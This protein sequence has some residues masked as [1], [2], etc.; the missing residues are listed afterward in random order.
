MFYAAPRTLDGVIWDRKPNKY[1]VERP[2]EKPWPHVIKPDAEMYIWS[3]VMWARITARQHPQHKN[4]DLYK[5]IY[6]K[7]KSDKVGTQ[8]AVARIW[9][10]L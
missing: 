4:L 10:E 7:R 1:R 6:F 3:S 5:T 2:V 9:S 8:K